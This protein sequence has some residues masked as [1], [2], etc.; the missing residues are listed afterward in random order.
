MVV[1]SQRD[2]S[3]M[4]RF[5]AFCAS[6]GVDSP[7]EAL[8]DEAFVAAFLTI[9]C[10]GLTPHSLGTY[11]S[12]LARI[13]GVTYRSVDGFSGCPAPRP[14]TSKE[15]A[16]LWSMAQNQSSLKRTE[17]AKVLLST[18]L[19]AGLRPGELARARR[20]DVV[21]SDAETLIIV[22]GSP[23]RAP[24][25]LSP[26][27]SE[28]ARL[29]DGSSLYLFRPGAKVRDQKNL[30]G[31]VCTGLVRDPDEVSLLARRARTTFICSHL[32]AGTPLLKLCAL[33]G[34][35]DVESLLRYARHVDGAPRSKAQLR[36]LAARQ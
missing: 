27:R 29:A 2:R 18:M 35:K 24:C 16:A 6:E 15:V 25:V 20:R 36:A 11:R 8:G 9:G 23:T 4:E 22:R 21:T 12:V 34:L 17:R 30:V 33:A 26:Y 13:G 14:Y 7:T 31:E 10:L 19:G 5:V 32:K 28:L 1:L 3:V